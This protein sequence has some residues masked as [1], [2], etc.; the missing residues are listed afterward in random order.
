LEA[1]LRDFAAEEGMGLGKVAQPVR[2]ALT[3]RTI[4]PS[5]FEMMEILGREES[6]S[7]LGDCAE[8]A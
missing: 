8:A 5:V 3:G 2:A 7:R 4:S 1:S 6:L